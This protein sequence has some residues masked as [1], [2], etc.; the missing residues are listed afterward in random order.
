MQQKAAFWP[1]PIKTAPVGHGKASQ[2]LLACHSR[3]MHCSHSKITGLQ[4]ISGVRWG[5]CCQ[6]LHI[7]HKFQVICSQNERADSLFKM[8]TRAENRVVKARR[9]PG[10]AT[11]PPT[12]TATIPCK[13]RTQKSNAMPG[14]AELGSKSSSRL[15]IEDPTK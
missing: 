1:W 13:R 8:H 4:L 14:F 5:P 2:D 11:S 10:Q 3:P 9:H 7:S 15:G 6:S 12:T